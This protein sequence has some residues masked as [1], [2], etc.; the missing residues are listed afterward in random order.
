MSDRSGFFH[1]AWRA[2]KDQ[3]VQAV[4][5]DDQF[6]E[7]ECPYQRCL[8]ETTGSCEIRPRQTLVILR[9]SLVSAGEAWVSTTPAGP[10]EPARVA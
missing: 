2:M 8:I 6:C 10:A 9:T 3:I 5:P 7:F 4:P 1:R